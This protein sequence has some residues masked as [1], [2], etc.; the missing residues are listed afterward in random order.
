MK[1][2]EY[3][4]YDVCEANTI[5]ELILTNEDEFAEDIAIKYI[6]RRKIID[7]SY[8]QLKKD[9]D[10]L[11]TYFYMKGIKNKKVAILGSNSYEW[12]LGFLTLTCSNNVAVP[13]DKSLK[14]TEILGILKKTDCSAIFL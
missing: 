8:S 5:K 9:I 2:E 1:N 6:N 13:I 14:S 3:A 11:G 12:A 10:C 7:I 4:F